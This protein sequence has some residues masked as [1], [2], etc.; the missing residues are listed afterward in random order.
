MVDAGT[1]GIGTLQQHHGAHA[2]GL[3][4]V[5]HRLGHDRGG[6]HRGV[7]HGEAPIGV[8]EAEGPVVLGDERIHSIGIEGVGLV[9]PPPLGHRSRDVLVE[10]LARN[11][12]R[13]ADED[14]PQHEHRHDRGR[15]QRG[16]L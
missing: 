15:P 9:P 12:R 2:T 14:R 5:E 16:R 3:D 4:C 10:A 8:R 13:P 6:P 1:A 11:R 7:V